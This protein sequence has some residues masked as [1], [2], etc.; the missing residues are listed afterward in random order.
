VE[1]LL[2]SSFSL[3][4]L[5][6]VSFFNFKCIE[7]E[8]D[9]ELEVVLVTCKQLSELNL[10]LLDRPDMITS[11]SLDWLGSDF[12]D[13]LLVEEFPIDC[14]LEK[15]E[16]LLEQWDDLDV[17]DGCRMC[18]L[19]YCGGESLI[20]SFWSSGIISPFEILL[21]RNYILKLSSR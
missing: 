6:E 19:S 11:F 14:L 17:V 8:C 21:I 18:S 7:W 4:P 10:L 3:L 16:V 20:W 1:E 12:S 2:L 13:V 5:A 9:C 15:I